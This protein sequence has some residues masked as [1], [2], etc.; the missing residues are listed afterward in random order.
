MFLF[1]FLLLKQGAI[2]DPGGYQSDNDDE[3]LSWR[4]LIYWFRCSEVNT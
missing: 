3:L 4:A 1:Y 2:E